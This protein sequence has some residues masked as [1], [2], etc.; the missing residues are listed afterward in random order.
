ME[1]SENAHFHY[2]TVMD[3]L[4]V[5]GQQGF[6]VDFNLADE[7]ITYPVQ[8]IENQDFEIVAV[9]RYEG[10]TDPADEAVVYGIQTKL[11]IRG[12]LVTGYGMY[13]GAISAQILKKLHHDQFEPTV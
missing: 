7:I 5:L 8:E 1:D 3:A 4:A 10:D 11:G 6:T 9:Y 2:G 12:T 13:A